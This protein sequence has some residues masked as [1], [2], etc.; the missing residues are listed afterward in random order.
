LGKID[1]MTLR[2]AC[3]AWFSKDWDLFVY[4]WRSYTFWWT[5]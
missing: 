3:G 2:L 4:S 1:N 5:M